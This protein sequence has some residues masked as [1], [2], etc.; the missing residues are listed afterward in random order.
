LTVSRLFDEVNKETGHFILEED[1][2]QKHRNYLADIF[3]LGERISAMLDVM[4][5]NAILGLF[6]FKISSPKPT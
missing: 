5:Y 6:R 3:G 1:S 4:W 2:D